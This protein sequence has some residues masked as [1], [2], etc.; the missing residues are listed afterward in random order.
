MRSCR[1]CAESNNFGIDGTAGDTIATVLANC[2]RYSPDG[3][4]IA[5]GYMGRLWVSTSGGAP[6]E[7]LSEGE[8]IAGLSWSPDGASV[9]MCVS[10]AVGRHELWFG[11]IAT[12][13]T[14]KL[15]NAQS[16]ANPYFP[17]WIE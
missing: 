17:Q 2:P 9:V 6:S 12:G 4:K 16:S 14:T 15:T 8:E 7:V 1:F 10:N 11:E 5:Y 13:V 3:N